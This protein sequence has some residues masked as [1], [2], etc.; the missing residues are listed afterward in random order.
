MGGEGADVKI[1]WKTDRFERQRAQTSAHGID[2]RGE[3]R[4][5]RH[6]FSQL[7]PIPGGGRGAG[8]SQKGEGTTDHGARTNGAK[9]GLAHNQEGAVRPRQRVR[10][11]LGKYSRKKG[12]R[13]RGDADYVNE[14]GKTQLMT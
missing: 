13:K 11:G 9:T 1:L 12:S 3:W 8:Q 4:D 7:N 6:N 14:K 5:G 2:A 10:Y